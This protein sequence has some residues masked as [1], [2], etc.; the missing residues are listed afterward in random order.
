MD[1]M[2]G[3]FII[4]DLLTKSNAALSVQEEWVIHPW[5]VLVR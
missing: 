4:S 1:M 3:A 2:G 5:V